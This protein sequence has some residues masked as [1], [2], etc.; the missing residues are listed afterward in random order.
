MRIIVPFAPGGGNDIVARVMTQRLTVALGQQ[1]IVENRPGAGGS[2][3][4]E[5][6]LKS[7]PDGYT[8]TV[9]PS[10]YTA[11]ASLYKLKFDPVSDIAPIVQLARSP[12]VDVIHPSVPLK[13]IAGL[14][15]LA[16][17]KPGKLNFATPG[18]GTTLHLATELFA[19][20]AGIKMNHVPYKGAGPALTD[21]IA[22]HT[23]LDFSS[24]P[25]ALPHIKS[26]R[27]R[28]IAVTTNQ[29]IPA[30]QD[31]PTVAES[32]LPGYEVILWYG[33]AGPKGLPRTIVDRINAEVTIALKSKEVTEQFLNDGL[34]HGG[35]TPEQFLEII[36][37]EIAV[38]RKVVRDAGVRIQ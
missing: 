26:G 31:I 36:R 21:T 6:G 10:S 19:S 33:L 23:D 17:S 22:G 7:P 34:F 24:I 18:Q 4:V 15:A 5:A 32:G 25:P 35:G 14:I 8:L 30:V 9:I 16:K 11:N 28:A 29:R 20:M 3:G 13:T 2:I 1:F 12:L 27:L 38:W 37:K